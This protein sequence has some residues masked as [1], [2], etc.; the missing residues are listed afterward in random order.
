M[1]LN[2]LHV[3]TEKTWRGG[4]RQ[5]Y[6]L[7]KNLAGSE[8]INYVAAPPKNPF[9]K[10]VQTLP[11][12]IIP[13]TMRGEWD[14]CAAWR[15]S[16]II[17]EY[18]INLVHAHTSHALGIAA[19][20]KLFCSVKLVA[21]RRV[22]YALRK[23]IFSALKYRS[24]DRI[25]AISDAIKRILI[26]HGIP[27]EKIEVVK[28]GTELK[29]SSPMEVLVLWEDLPIPPE[30][31]LIGIV[32]ALTAQKDHDTF[33]KAAK[34]VK[35]KLP[36]TTFLIVGEGQRR[37][38]IT[39]LITKLGLEND[40]I[41]TG[42]RDDVMDLIELMDVYVVSSCFEGMGTSTLDAMFREK[43]VVATNVGGIPEIVEDGKTGFLVP[44][45][46]DKAMAEKIIFLFNNKKKAA[47]MGK[48]GREKVKDFSVEKTA[49][50]TIQVYKK[51]LAM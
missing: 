30:N 13:F 35:E 5:A 47:D 27:E 21:S 29:R 34:R 33:V 37:K 44:V 4:E 42:F 15:L 14:I 18:D 43:P 36:N 40:I 16:R 50:Q 32:G 9:F 45:G 22:D 24:A 3:D 28:S 7:I 26:T 49:K 6:F 46:D 48:A 1:P 11:C 20:A 41:M 51:V 31:N 38:D 2:L 19:L 25:I 23:N 10:Q 39:E 12:T 8:F 17:K